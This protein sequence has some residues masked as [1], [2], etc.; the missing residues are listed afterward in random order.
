M[1]RLIEQRGGEVFG[2][3]VTLIE[4]FRGFNFIEQ[5]LRHRR[6]GLIMLRVILKHVRPARPHFIHLRRVFDKIP[7]H[8]RSAEPRIFHIGKH[9]MKRVT[10]FVK[11]SPHFVVCQQRRLAGRGFRNIEMVHDHWFEG[12]QLALLNVGI[13]PCTAAL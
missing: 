6:A 12:E 1:P 9:S 4:F 8:A 7:R 10:K 3:F 5:L 11:R 2:R 13:H